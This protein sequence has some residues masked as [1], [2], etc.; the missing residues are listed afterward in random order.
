MGADRLT[1]IYDADGTLSGEIAYLF[2]SRFKGEHCSLCDITHTWHG[3]RS[4]F[5]SAEARLNL[6]VEYLHRNDLDEPTGAAYASVRDAL[7]T[8]L[9]HVGDRWIVALG[10]EQLEACKGD[11]RA[12][13]HALRTALDAIPY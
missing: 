1:F 4:E 11:V 6:P 9:A 10:P 12:F 13:E 2:R 7:P 8:V 3:K 5:T